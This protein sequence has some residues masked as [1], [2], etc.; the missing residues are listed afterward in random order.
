MQATQILKL[1]AA[2]LLVLCCLAACNNKKSNTNASNDNTNSIVDNKRL[3]FDTLSYVDHPAG[4][5]AIDIEISIQLPIVDNDIAI[6]N[7]LRKNMLADVIGEKYITSDDARSNLKQHIAA[8]QSD[9][10]ASMA[11]LDFVP[12][13]AED[14][15]E[16]M[17]KWEYMN[18]SNVVLY[19]GQLLVYRNLFYGYQGGAHGFGGEQYSVYSTSSGKKLTTN[20]IFK[21]D[22][23]SQAA[24]AQIVKKQLELMMTNDEEYANIEI[25]DWDSVKPIDNYAVDSDGI[26]FH[27][28]PY[29]IA[30]YCYGQLAIKVPY[31]LIEP[32]LNEGTAVQLYFKSTS[33]THQQL[34]SNN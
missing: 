17:F 22:T 15:M 26:T 20:D 32:Y 10:E 28:L 29:E 8:L 6:S 3:S 30:P 2:T 23:T 18:K 9:F 25:F 7:V 13:E 16:Y 1:T 27:Y 4:I 21:T 5:P 14:G 31:T 34:A 33:P 19:E 24:M 12:D 11:E